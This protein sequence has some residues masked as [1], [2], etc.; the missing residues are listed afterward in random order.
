MSGR[1][2]RRRCTGVELVKVIRERWGGTYVDALVAVEIA[3]ADGDVVCV[4][5]GGVLR[6][7][8]CVDYADWGG[9]CGFRGA[10]LGEVAI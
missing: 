9:E 2:G 3:E 6:A 7:E 10:G 4:V 1:W 5:A 8:R